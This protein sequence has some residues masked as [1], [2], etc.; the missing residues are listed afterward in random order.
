M[1]L[2]D[3][4]DENR[5]R[6]GETLERGCARKGTY[7]IVVHACVFN[8]KGEMLIQQRQPFK[9]GWANL[10]DVTM[11]GHAVTGESS[12]EA[13]ERELFE[14]VG[15]RLDL[16]DTRP[17][18]TLNFSGGFDDYYLIE[19]EVDIERLTLQY[20][21]VQCVKW[22]TLEEIVALIDSGEFIPYYREL[23]GL[24]FAM[25]F[26]YSARFSDDKAPGLK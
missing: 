18:L 21:E 3:V 19:A 13:A 15:I 2:W 25:R 11:G 24:L 4:Y 20:E 6:T 10:W 1:E 23:I 17:H 22:A 12:R 5:I 14:E 8:S 16:K 9:D 7:Y 26:R